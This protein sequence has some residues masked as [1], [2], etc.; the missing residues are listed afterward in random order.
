MNKPLVSVLITSYNRENYIADCLR[1]V[2]G[3]SYENFEVIVVDDC[4]TDRTYEIIQ[5]F[6]KKD[7]RVKGYRNNRNLGQFQNRNYIASLANGEFLKYL[8]S[9]D[10]IYHYGIEMMVYH[11]MRYPDAA[12]FISSAELHDDIPF[13][14][15]LSPIEIYTRFYLS[16]GFPS[17]GP[18]AILIKTSAF[19][20]VGG[21][22]VPSFVGSDTEFILKLASKFSVVK[23]E[24]GVIW[25]RQ[26][27]EQEMVR[28]IKSNE[29]EIHDYQVFSK[30]LLASDCPLKGEA[31][32]M[33]LKRLRKR[34]ARFIF[35]SLIKTDFKLAFF[36]YRQLR[37]SLSELFSVFFK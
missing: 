18:S 30:I 11:A 6:E 17:V 5:E 34:N 7:N 3:S 9:D 28:G 29:Y 33:A 25:Y 16:G 37:P 27:D 23:T 14:F 20:S 31:N 26:H 22:T 2:L 19:H 21:F 12:L 10:V 13:P 1:S 35:R 36:I 4:S 15:E 32:T 24:P 8:D